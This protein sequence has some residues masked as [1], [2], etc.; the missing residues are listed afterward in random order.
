MAASNM[1][2]AAI[3][4]HSP[5]SASSHTAI[6][7]AGLAGLACAQVM[8][9][10]GEQVTLFD[11]ARG[12]GGRMS[13]K[14]RPEAIL[15]L[16]AQAFTVRDEAFNEEVA[17][18]QAAGCVGQW[19][20]RIYRASP[21][22]WQ[23]HHDG[24]KRFTGLPSMSAI[25]RHLTD[26]LV[27][28]DVALHSTTPI[29][30]LI[31]KSEGWWLEG[32]NTELYGPYTQVVI[33]APPPQA[34]ILV[35]PWDTQLSE[36]CQSL[37]QRGC[38]AGWAVFAAPLPTPVGIKKDWQMARV[39]HPALRL[40]C[41]NQTKPGR[42]NQPESLSLL[43]NLEW[44]ETHLEAAPEA[45]T[46]SLLEAL[47]SLYP[48]PLKLP[49]LL[50]SGAHRWRYSQPDKDNPFPEHGYARSAIGLALCGDSLRGGRV[51]DAWLSGHRLGL[52]L[53]DADNTTTRPPG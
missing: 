40:V 38:W 42:E 22:G 46:Q 23:P 20:E 17:R 11:K 29:T 2:G 3:S 12:P 26:S 33:S 34:S 53:L 13:S 7:G 49:E 18:W 28:R 51:E 30:A 5:D 8:V 41:R 4:S 45:I 10:A 25:T 14:H 50:D 6:I 9:D 15:D 24:Q 47:K 21:T 27:A 52:S 48:A 16:G 43:A 37:V 1:S 39:D 35:Q 32:N 19:P 31:R 44:S 36:L